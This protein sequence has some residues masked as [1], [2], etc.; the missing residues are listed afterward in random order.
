MTIVS[1]SVNE[2]LLG[3]FDETSARNGY[4]TRSEA[5]RDAMR[6]FVGDAELEIEGGENI[7][8]ISLIYAKGVNRAELIRVQHRFPEIQT[9]LH[10]HLDDKNCLEVYILKGEGERLKKLVREIRH[11]KAVKRVDFASNASNV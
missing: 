4:S 1:I 3:K 7:A 2:E 5:I 9:M 11:I 10:T 8:I 6:A